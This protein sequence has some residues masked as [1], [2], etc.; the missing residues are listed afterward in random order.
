V[1]QAACVAKAD[2]DVASVLLMT[3]AMDTRHDGKDR[4]FWGGEA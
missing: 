2:K 4:H 3:G 1:R